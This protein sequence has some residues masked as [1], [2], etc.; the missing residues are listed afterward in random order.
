MGNGWTSHPW[1]THRH[2]L[3]VIVLDAMGVRCGLSR[4]L[5][6]RSHQSSAPDKDLGTQCSVL[7]SPRWEGPARRCGGQLA[8]SSCPHLRALFFFIGVS[9]SLLSSTLLL[10]QVARRDR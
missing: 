6:D 5:A 8:A 10:A 9:V 7:A 2:P 3:M 1:R 4:S